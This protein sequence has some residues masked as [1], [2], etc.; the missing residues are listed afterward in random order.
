MLQSLPTTI[1]KNLWYLGQNIFWLGIWLFGLG[2]LATYFMRWWPGDKFVFVRLFN[3]LMPWVLIAL[4]PALIITILGHR[5]WL[6]TVLTLSTLLIAL[7]YAPLFLPR[8]SVA[9]ADT[10]PFK[11]MSYNIWSR[12]RDTGNITQL[13][14]EQQADILLLQE[15]KPYQAKQL[16]AELDGLYGDSDTN[17]VYEPR[18]EQAVVS[19]YP[20]TPAGA[21]RD[22]GRAQKVIAQTPNGP[23][24]IWNL[25]PWSQ[26]GWQ[27]RYEQISALMAEIETTAPNEAIILGGDFNTTDQTEIYKLVTSQLNS[28]H[29]EAGWGF[30]FTFPAPTRRFRGTIAFPS[31]VRID[32]IFYSDHFYAHSAETLSDAGG[33]DHLPVTTQLSWIK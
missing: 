8:P 30:G 25:H 2:I 10:N 13:I 21:Y 28:A 7:N 29:W 26:R 3:Y 33:S 12:N 24:T 27:L 31:L 5:K 32:H 14:R 18:V 6:G 11:V 20:L 9:L 16:M 19:R 4:I 23:V 17:F 15:V 1:I 22:K